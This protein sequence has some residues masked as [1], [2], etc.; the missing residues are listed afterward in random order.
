MTVITADGGVCAWDSGDLSVTG[1]MQALT[2]IGK[3]KLFPNR[4][5]KAISLK[6]AMGEFA[7]RAIRPERGKPIQLFKLQDGVC[8]FE[9]R[10]IHPAE[11]SVDPVPLFTA[12]ADDDDVVSIIRHNPD[13]LPKMDENLATCNKYIQERYDDR[14]QYIHASTVTAVLNNVMRQLKTTS[15]RRSG[16]C[17]WVPDCHLQDIQTFSD[18]LAGENTDFSLNVL[19]STV[20]ANESTFKAIAESV[21]EQMKDR[22][23]EIGRQLDNLETRQNENGKTS[24]TAECYAI[25][26][27]AN[28]YSSFL[29]SELA[30]YQQMAE[31][32]KE[33]VSIASVMDFCA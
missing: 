26:D 14:R 16:G 13:E 8:G 19:R 2:A 4:S 9:A 27:L 6:E 28:E 17:Y 24:R 18:A 33:R 21:K 10:Q 3:E 32:M 31:D 5:N 25:L 7:R 20:T 1:L 29:G 11:D 22:L 23:E 15:I 12:I 30:T